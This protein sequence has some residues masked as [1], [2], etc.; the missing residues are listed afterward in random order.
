[1]GFVMRV[2]FRRT[3]TTADSARRWTILWF[4]PILVVLLT[5]GCATQ[6]RDERP[7]SKSNQ[8]TFPTRSYEDAKLT[9]TSVPDLFNWNIAY[10]QPGWENAMDWFLGGMKKEGPAFM[11]NAGDIM[12]ARWWNDAEQIRKRTREYW[13]GFKKRFEDKNI[14]VYIAPGDH[15]YGDDRGLR[16]MH[17]TPVFAEQFANIFDMPRNGPDHKKGRAYS[18]ERK[19]LAVVTVDTFEKSGDH[20]AMTVSGKQLDWLDRRLQSYDEKDFVIVQGHVPVLGPVR[21]KNSSANM[22]EDGPDSA[23]WGTLVEHDVDLYLSGEHHRITALKQDGI[24]QVV[25]G[26]LWGT[27]NDVNYLRGI[28]FGNRLRIELFRFPVRY[29]GGYIGNHPHRG[30]KNRPRDTVIIPDRVK[31]NGPERAGV[32]EIETGDDGNHTTKATGVF[33]G[34]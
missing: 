21:S 22:L 31:K 27:Q 17:L 24:W 6:G 9:F 18:F 29:D 7:S 1:M 32:L 15:E 25:H 14:D 13:G 33:S 30:P 3:N 26:A 28:V 10:P 16:M 19:N 23:F 5:A 34:K 8:F 4:V 2:C 20:L 12:D 11:L